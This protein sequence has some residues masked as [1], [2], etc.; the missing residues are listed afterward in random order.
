MQEKK[1][2]NFQNVIMILIA[3]CA[4]AITAIMVYQLAL[5]NKQIELLEAELDSCRNQIESQASALTEAGEQLGQYE[6][7]LGQYKEQLTSYA[8]QIKDMLSDEE[9]TYTISST[10]EYAA[11]VAA[12]SALEPYDLYY[13][14]QY[15]YEQLVELNSEYLIG[16]EEYKAALN[17]LVPKNKQE[18]LSSYMATLKRYF[19]TEEISTARSIFIDDLVSAKLLND[20]GNNYYTWSLATLTTKNIMSKLSLTED[21]ANALMGL[22][23][24]IDW[25]V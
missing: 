17:L 12:Q 22:L 25:D 13:D 11:W 24:T 8:E 21:V 9:K 14:L 6:A 2:S 3:V 5:G 10:K 18:D 4:V 16:T 23:R 7:Q 15:A 1:T 20:T 19:D